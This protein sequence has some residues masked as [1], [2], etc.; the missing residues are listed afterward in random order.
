[1]PWRGGARRDVA[2]GV[3]RGIAGQD[4]AGRGAAWQE[5]AWRGLLRITRPSNSFKEVPRYMET[6]FG[7]LLGDIDARLGLSRTRMPSARP[8]PRSL[9]GRGCE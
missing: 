7:L 8:S 9:P 3:V 2:W 1:M 5:V 6:R 4:E